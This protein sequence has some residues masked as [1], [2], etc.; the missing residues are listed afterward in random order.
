LSVATSIA[1]AGRWLLQSGIQR[2]SGGFARYYDAETGR[3][4]AVSTEI[5]GYAASALAWLFQ[6]TG[7]QSYL[8]AARR[9]AGFLL[10]AWDPVLRT[11]PFEHPSPSPES[12]HLAYFFD[13]GIIIRGLLAVWRET[14]RE[15]GADQFLQIASAAAHGMLADF[16]SHPE[17]HPILAL[18]SKSPLPRTEQWSRAPGCYQLKSALAWHD[19][20]AI[21]GDAAL[22]DA[23][24]EMLN[25]ALASHASFL[26]GSTCRQRVMDRLHP[27]CYFL[28]GL[29]AE[30]S[31]ANCAA[32]FN[33]GIVS[34][35][36]MLR[37]IAPVFA[38]SDVY[39]QLLRARL[40]GA[41]VCP[42]DVAA[43]TEEAEAL[44]GFQA[45]SEDP[46]IHGGFYFG[47]RE[48]R[49]SSHVNP[50]S[51][52]FAIQALEMWRQFQTERLESEGK[53][54]C[55]TLLI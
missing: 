13:C 45:V 54:P 40:Y 29:T 48:G 8:D 31:R 14:S 5:S 36:R 35:S 24:L 49:V 19:V 23:W 50:V 37:G 47:R 16:Q 17:Y 21:T 2:S 3:Y 15:T 55:A 26:P 41:C 43:A 1:P 38:R 34:T 32:A 18:P 4:R 44:A 52:V 9:T 53:A 27:Y 39:A 20:A 46:R 22:Q 10:N 51:T 28:E 25:E 12:E 33:E 11:F 7:D 30:M 6:V 42:V